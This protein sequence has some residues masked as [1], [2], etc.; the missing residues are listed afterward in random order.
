MFLELEKKEDRKLALIDSDGRTVTYGQLKAFAA[1]MSEIL[2][3]RCLVFILCRN[4]AGAAAVYLAALSNRIVPLMLGTNID[5]SLL[6]ELIRCYQPS[7]IWK[8]CGTTEVE[9]NVVF[10]A[11]DYDLVTCKKGSDRMYEELSLLLPTS[12]STGSPKLVRHSYHNLEANAQNITAFFKLD[13]SHR[14]M[15]DLPVQYTYGLSVLNSHLY[16]G[17]TILLTDFSIMQREYWDFFRKNKATSITGVPYTYEMLKAFRIFK[18]ELPSLK[19]LSQGGGKLREDLQQEYAQFANE[20][21][22][23]FVITYGQTEGSA[24]MAYLP[25]EDARKKIGSIG[26][27]IPG[28]RIYLVDEKGNKIAQTGKPGEMVYEGPNVTLGYAECKEELL[29]G[30]ERKGLLHTGD[31]AKQD[32]DGYLYI[33]GR[34]KRFLKLYGNRIS[35]DECEQL[36]QK[37]YQ[38]ECACTGRDN[39]MHIYIVGDIHG[40]VIHFLSETTHINK[41]AFHMKRIEKLPRNEAGKILYSDLEKECREGF[42]S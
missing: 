4:S 15:L 2:P 13:G 35:L 17:A 31:I 42:N 20:T 38:I 26:K 24:R 23:E 33:V 29:R 27:A 16:A 39:E 11:F 21:G 32:E 22:R 10:H 30:D 25:A 41:K 19:L 3:D 7:Y 9:E 5:R 36:I 1:K 12:G 8:P 34:K 40:D 37:E 28:G 6:Q 18:M 14:P